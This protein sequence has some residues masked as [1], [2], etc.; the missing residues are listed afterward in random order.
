MSARS[1]EEV[2]RLFAA[3][4]LGVSVS[5]LI[6]VDLEMDELGGCPTSPGSAGIE[7]VARIMGGS[8]EP[9]GGRV[10]KFWRGGDGPWYSVNF[11]DLGDVLPRMIEIANA[12]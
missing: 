1:Y 9:S 6:A 5:D 11:Y 8:P 3:E 4:A 12:P 2:V 10:T 7:L